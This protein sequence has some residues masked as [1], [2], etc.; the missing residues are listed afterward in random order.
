MEPK[1]TSASLV[2]RSSDHSANQR[3]ATA[4]AALTA[5][6][7]AERRLPTALVNC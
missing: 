7:E 1:A 6:S 4:L 2:S 5:A 3:V